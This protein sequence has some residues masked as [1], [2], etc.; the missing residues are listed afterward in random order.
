[1]SPRR[2]TF[3]AAALLPGGGVRDL[4]GPVS[5]GDG[6]VDACYDE[7]ADYG[8]DP[9]TQVPEFH[10]AAAEQQVADPA[11]DNGPDDAEHEAGDPAAADPARHDCLNDCTYYESENDPAYK[12]HYS[13]YIF[14]G[15]QIVDPD[16]GFKLTPVGLLVSRIIFNRYLP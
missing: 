5:P 11:A 7:A 14:V 2:R 9:G 8:Q 6:A 15:I 12:A 13:S 10:L 1:M 4:R 16:Y 3:T